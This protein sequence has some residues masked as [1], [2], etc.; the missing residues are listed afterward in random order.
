MPETIMPL[1][2]FLQLNSDEQVEKLKRWKMDYTLKDIREAWDFKHS[3]QYYMLLKKLRIYERVVNKSDKFYPVPDHLS[4][5]SGGGFERGW[6]GQPSYAQ[7]ELKLPADQFNYN[8]NTTLSG[9]ELAEKLERLAFFL[10]G[11]QKQ[12]AISLSLE[13]AAAVAVKESETTEE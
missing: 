7:Q 5:Q 2:D 1:D 8:L 13:A 10:K 11:E 3:A 6:R 4:S 12:V 9:A